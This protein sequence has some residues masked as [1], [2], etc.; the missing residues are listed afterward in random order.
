MILF[1]S[2]LLNEYVESDHDSDSE[3]SY[4]NVSTHDS[5]IYDEDLSDGDEEEGNEKEK[6]EEDDEEVKKSKSAFPFDIVNQNNKPHLKMERLGMDIL[7]S[8]EEASAMILEKMKQIT[9][10][11]LGHSIT[12]AVVTV[13]AYFND[14]QRQV[15]FLTLK[16][17]LTLTLK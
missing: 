4:L 6:V 8:P 3:Q 16:L 11:F 5:D 15:I 10:D 9:E 2:L 1:Y 12:D 7:L 17:T 14:A 13:P